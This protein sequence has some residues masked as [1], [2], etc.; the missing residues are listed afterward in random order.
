MSRAELV[1]GGREHRERPLDEPANAPQRVVHW[2]PYLAPNIL[3]P[4]RQ[5]HI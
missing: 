3:A 2:Q 1:E 4:H 5:S